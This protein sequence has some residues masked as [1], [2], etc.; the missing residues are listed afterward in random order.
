MLG[1]IQLCE[2]AFSCLCDGVPFICHN[3]VGDLTAGLLSE[4]C[5]D[6]PT[7]SHY[8]VSLSIL[9][10]LIEKMVLVLM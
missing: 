8:S 7:P 5:R 2:H 3:E 6:E 1:V 9:L 10:Q 4:V